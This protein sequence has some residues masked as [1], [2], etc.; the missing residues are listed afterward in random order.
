[1]ESHAERGRERGFGEEEGNNREMMM[2]WLARDFRGLMF[3]RYLQFINCT[4]SIFSF[5]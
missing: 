2:L 1:M 4:E 5:E 3:P